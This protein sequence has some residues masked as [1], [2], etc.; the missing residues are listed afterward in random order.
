MLG[1][2]IAGMVVWGYR[3]FR[4]GGVVEEGS[5]VADDRGRLVPGATLKGFT[6]L[7]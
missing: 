7:R 3:Q 2:A 5:G 4:H 6:E 1:L